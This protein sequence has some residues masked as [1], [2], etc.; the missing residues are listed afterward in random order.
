MPYGTKKNTYRLGYE[1]FAHSMAAFHLQ[2][3]KPH[4]RVLIGGTACTKPY[5]LA[6]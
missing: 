6:Y 5:M 2:G 1:W 4:S 3:K